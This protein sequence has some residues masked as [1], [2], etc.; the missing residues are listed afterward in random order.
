MHGNMHMIKKRSKRTTVQYTV[1]QV[2]RAVRKKQKS[3]Q[4]VSSG[5]NQLQ[6]YCQD[7]LKKWMIKKWDTW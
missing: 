3:C 4:T 1:C 5:P 7:D 2:A 6:I